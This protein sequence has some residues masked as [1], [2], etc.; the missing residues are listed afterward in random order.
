MNVGEFFVSLG[1][2][3]D[4]SWKDGMAR[5][6][7]IAQVARQV[8]RETIAA[9]RATASAESAH[10]KEVASI[11]RSVGLERIRMSKQVADAAVAASRREAQ[12]AKEASRAQFAAARAALGPGPGRR[13]RGINWASSTGDPF[14][15]PNSPVRKVAR[16]MA[17]TGRSAGNYAMDALGDDLGASGGGGSGFGKGNWQLAHMAARRGTAD[18]EYVMSNDGDGGQNWA[19]G[20]KRPGMFGRFMGRYRENFGGGKSGRR[21]GG[22]GGGFG[23]HGRNQFGPLGA[24][25]TFRRVVMGAGVY[26]SA[27]YFGDLAD[28][29]AQLQMRLNGLTGSQEKSNE[30]FARLRNI[31]KGTNSS[32]ESTTEGYVRIRNATESMNLSEEDSFKL[33]TNLNTLLA[34]SGASSSEAKSGMLQLT[35]ALAKG[36]LDGD[37]FRS[38][39]ENMPN[40]LKVLQKSLGVT[41]GRLREMSTAGELTRDKLVKALLGVTNLQKPVDTFST[42]WQKFKDDMMVTFGEI[43]K[44]ENLVADFNE[45]LK[46]FAVFLTWI[47]KRLPGVIRGLKDFAKYLQENRWALYALVSV[48]TAMMIPALFRLI[49]FPFVKLIESYKALAA[50]WAF[51]GKA[52]RLFGLG[53]DAAAAAQAAAGAGQ[54]AGGAAAAGAGSSVLGTAGQFARTWGG[55]FLP[56]PAD[57]LNNAERQQLLGNGS[58]SV[59]ARLANGTP[60]EQLFNSPGQTTNSAKN[61]KIDN[62]NVEIK[63]NDMTD[64]QQKF[65][66]EMDKTLRQA[67]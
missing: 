56:N 39:A 16:S 46:Y 22:G 4:S 17:P 25:S 24:A 63:A 65:G 10:L 8:S 54:A 47:V 42:T 50:V 67:L 11:A 62:I 57:L 7:Q 1:L 35:Q 36:R 66:A 15:G 19:A 12:A 51:A 37:E 38:M 60:F 40:V 32:L 52:G 53:A 3:P 30:V 2:K 28:T 18:R 59:S 27:Q 61:I 55:R 23:E 58:D 9:S 41:E 34:T 29:Y 33:M 45:L 31:A 49:A 43:A 21:G 26:Q 13:G 5:I 64:A 44:N 14:G 20:K 6:R 48:I